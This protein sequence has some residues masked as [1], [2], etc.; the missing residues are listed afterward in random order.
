MSPEEQMMS[1]EVEELSEDMKRE[2]DAEARK[3]VGKTSLAFIDLETMT[4]A[5]QAGFLVFAIVLFGGLGF[6]FYNALFVEKEDFNKKKRAEY[7]ARRAK[8]QQ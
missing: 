4:P 2:S 6:F 3:T 5:M 1:S 7:E 8:K